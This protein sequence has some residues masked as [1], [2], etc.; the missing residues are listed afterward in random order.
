MNNYNQFEMIIQ[1][2]IIKR[3]DFLDS[4]RRTFGKL[5]KEQGKVEGDFSKKADRCKLIGIASVNDKPVAIGAIKP[6]TK[7]DFDSIKADLASLS[8]DFEW[9]LGYIFTQKEHLGNGIASNMVKLLI[10]EFGKGNLMASTEISANPAMVKILERNGFRHYG[11]PWKST[12][13]DN[14]LGLF[15]KFE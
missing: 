6:K 5:L 15:L 10:K 3:I 9:E 14:Y 12:I 2:D 13:H 11:K 7:S 4:H 8:D 1:Y